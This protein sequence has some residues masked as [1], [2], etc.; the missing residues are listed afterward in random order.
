MLILRKDIKVGLAVAAA[1]AGVAVV[2]VGIAAFS[3][4]GTPKASGTPSGGAAGQTA[5]VSGNATGI[6][7]GP[8]RSLMAERTAALPVNGGAETDTNA[9]TTDPFRE[10]NRTDGKSGER[11]DNL[12]NNGPISTTV[13]PQF[14]AN[15]ALTGSRTAGTDAGKTAAGG[16]NTG[17][18]ND[19][20]TNTAGD[21]LPRMQKPTTDQ[22]PTLTGTSGSGATAGGASNGKP[23]AQPGAAGTYVV[24]EGDTLSSIARAIYGKSSYYLQLA[25]ANPNIDPNRMRLGT[26]LVIPPL[27]SIAPAP[28][29]GAPAIGT[30]QAGTGAAGTTIDP[31]TE[32]RV[33]SGDSLNR[34]AARLYGDSREWAKIY[35]L[36]KLAIGNDPAKLKLG[37]VLK[38]PAAPTQKTSG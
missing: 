33:Q 30:V 11:W 19:A 3:G 4:P 20:R 15:T 18:A 38:L 16:T 25:K 23:P 12:F 5:S 7:G 10:S 8:D 22:P 26:T 37:M 24:K 21:G 29:A 36:N 34:I 32:Y 28:T 2:Y 9:R 6:P 14:P 31:K 1:V 35:E 13:T 27:G 17:G